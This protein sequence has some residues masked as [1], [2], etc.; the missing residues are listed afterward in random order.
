MFRGGDREAGHGLCVILAGRHDA[1]EGVGAL[2]A[3][4]VGGRAHARRLHAA[5]AA[6]AEIMELEFDQAGIARTVQIFE[7]DLLHFARLSGHGAAVPNLHQERFQIAGQPIAGRIGVLHRHQHI[8]AGNRSTLGH[9]PDHDGQAAAMCFENVLPARPIEQRWVGKMP[10]H[11]FL[12]LINGVLAHHRPFEVF[13]E[14]VLQAEEDYLLPLAAAAFEI[15]IDPLGAGRVLLPMRELVT[16]GAK[17]DVSGSVHGRWFILSGS[18]V[19]LSGSPVILSGSEESYWRQAR[20]FA[21]A[22]DDTLRFGMRAAFPAAPAAK[23]LFAIVER[24][25]L[26]RSA[27]PASPRSVAPH[28]RESSFS[29]ST[30]AAHETMPL[31]SYRGLVH[32][33][34]RRPILRANRWSKTRTCPLSAAKR[35]SP[36]NDEWG[37]SLFLLALE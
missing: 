1:F 16:V 15:G 5:D 28:N 22:Q 9:C 20:S 26:G 3:Q 29:N 6:K 37:M 17:D 2:E 36:L 11:H 8:V 27:S 23:S 4:Q 34:A 13:L 19:I 31:E 25:R 10:P 30:S 12:G 24:G 32:F 21:I 14:I 35:D 33:S 18:P 7:D